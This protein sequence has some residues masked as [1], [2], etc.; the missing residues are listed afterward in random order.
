MTKEAKKELIIKKVEF[1][2]IKH[3]QYQD[4]QIDNQ[5][6]IFLLS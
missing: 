5:S 2:D 1:M 3:K 4:R 6:K